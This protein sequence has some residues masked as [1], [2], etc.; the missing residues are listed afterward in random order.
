MNAQSIINKVRSTSRTLLTEIESKI[1]LSEAGVP[2]IQTRLV[3]SK[4]EAIV[5]SKKLGF[6]V[7]LNS[8]ST[9]I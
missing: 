9:V 6:P 2:V 8:S 1:L 7:A 4:E 3:T 5:M